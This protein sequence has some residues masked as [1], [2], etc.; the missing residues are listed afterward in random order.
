VFKGKNK[1]KRFIEKG[2]K[3]TKVK[4]TDFLKAGAVLVPCALI[5]M[6]IASIPDPFETKNPKQIEQ[7]DRRVDAV[8]ACQMAVER[9]ATYDSDH[10]ILGMDASYREVGTN[11]TVMRSVKMMNGFGAWIPHFYN[12]HLRIA[13]NKIGEIYELNIFPGKR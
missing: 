11:A 8:V 10:S 13:N 4:V 7:S 6:C 3:M 2:L 9:S 12:C 5:G 1:S